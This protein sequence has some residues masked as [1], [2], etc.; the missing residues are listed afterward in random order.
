MKVGF[1]GLGIMGS[2]MAANLLPHTD[3]LIVHNRT[4][5][6]AEDV[7]AQGA[8]W[9]ETPAEVARQSEIV[10]TVLSTPEAVTQM[11]LGPDG[12][13]DQMQPQSLWVDCSTVNPSFTRSMAEHAHQHQVRLLD[14]PLLGTKTPAAEGQLLFA[15]GGAAEDIE[16][17]RPY[18]AAMG[19]DII[20]AGP[21]GAGT[22][23]KMVLNMLLGTSM[24]AFAEAFALGL[25]LGIPRERLLQTLPGSAVVAPF[26]SGKQAKIADDEYEADFPLR[27][28]HKDLHLAS[29]TAYEVGVAMPVEQAAKELFAMAKES[30]L[31]DQDFSAIVKW[32]TR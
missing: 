15:V 10:F 7:L 23:M 13:L 32:L 16:L 6:K 19:R 21:N 1:I 12:F 8:I 3:S 22:S 9:A 24:A 28:M 27:W 17:C 26:V 14:A 29:L 31:A 4:K 30:D 20:H 25:A 11:A 2:R 18:F 5:D